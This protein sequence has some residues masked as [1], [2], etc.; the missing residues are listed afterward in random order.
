MTSDENL[1]NSGNDEE[2][3]EAYEDDRESQDTEIEKERKRMVE[4]GEEPAN[5]PKRGEHQSEEQEPLSG[6]A[7]EAE[8]SLERHGGQCST[9]A[10]VAL[11]RTQDA[12]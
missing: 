4:D 8:C 6:F 10:G 9:R 5:Q 1:L 12:P 2:E 3:D 7:C 11:I